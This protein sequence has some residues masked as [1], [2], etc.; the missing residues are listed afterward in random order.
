M[1][2]VEEHQSLE[3]NKSKTKIQSVLI[4]TSSVLCDYT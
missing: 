1:M 3:P 4:E 2:E